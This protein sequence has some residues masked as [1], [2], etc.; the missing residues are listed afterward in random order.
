MKKSLIFIFAICAINVL[1][2][3]PLQNQ[4]HWIQILYSENPN[5]IELKNAY[6]EYFAAHPF[7]KSI[8]TQNYKRWVSQHRSQIGPDGFLK[9]LTAEERE[10]RRDN[11]EQ[12]QS[13]NRGG[14]DIWSYAG[15]EIH[16]V[17]DGT[18][19]EG[20][21]HSN[22][23]C[24]DRSAINAELL[25]CGTES[26]GAYKSV[27]GGMNWSNITASLIIG[28]VESMRI[29]PT[30][31]N[32]VIMS[33]TNDL[34]RTVDGGETWSVIGQP[35]FI[36]QNIR[37]S[38]IVF[39]PENPD[40]IYAATNLGFFR[41][42]D[43]GN[44]WTEVLTGQCRTVAQ[45]PN[46]AAIVYTIQEVDTHT[47]QFF[48]SE[49]YG[50]TWIMYNTGWFDNIG[51]QILPEGGRLAT[52]AAD[53]N[54][55]YAILVGYQE[56]NSTVITNGWI[57]AWVSYDAG[58][59]W[60]FPHGL[61]GSPY[62]L[63][64]HPNLM[65]FQ[66]DDGDYTQIN[67]NTTLIVSQLDPDKVLIGGLNL[68]KSTDAC[69]TYQGV[70]GYI[71]GIDYFHVDQQEYHIYKTSETTEE[72]WFSN[73][74]GIGFSSDFM[75][76]HLNLNRGIQAVNLWGYDQ[77]WNEDMMVGGR[78]HNGNM[79][80]HELYPAKEFLALGGGEAAT[81]YVN[82][83]D[84]NKTYFSDIGGVILPN[85]LDQGPGYFSMSLSPNESYYA[86]SSSR[87]M[88][89]NQYY[90]VA[91]LGKD[92]KL[93][94]STNGG[95][96]FG[97]F[98][99][100][101]TNTAN[102]VLWME[103][104]YA[105]YNIM[106]V[107]QAIGNNSQLWQTT[108]GGLT[109][110]EVNLPY[111]YREMV[112]TLSGTNDDELWI[113]YYYGSNGNK[114]YH[115]TDGGLNWDNITSN[116]FDGE[117]PWAIAHQYGT[118]GGVYLAV[119]NGLVFYKNNSISE[120]IVY[121][122]GLPAS[123]EPLRLVPFYKG[124]K[125]RLATWNLG[126]WE[127][128]FYESSE[129][130]VDFAA[131]LGTYYCPGDEMHFTDHSV[132]GPDATY[133]WSI[134]GATPSTSTEKN[135]TVVYDNSGTYDVTLSVTENGITESVTKT[136]YISSQ[137]SGSFPTAEG[138]ESSSFPEDWK[139]AHSSGGNGFWSMA[140]GIGGYG[141]SNNSM[142]FD[143][144]YY[145]ALG[146]RDEIWLEKIS[147]PNQSD[148]SPELKFDVAYAQYNDDPYTDTLAVLISADC[149]QSWTEIYVKGGEDLSTA[150]DYSTAVFVPG[151]TQWS[152]DMISLDP[153]IGEPEVIVA[154]Q[155]RGH[156]GQAIY[157]DNI[158]LQ[159]ST[160]V[161]DMAE[162][163]AM[164]LNLYP[165]PVSDFLQLSAKNITPS[166]VLVSIFDAS[167]KLVAEEIVKAGGIRLEK[168]MDVSKLTSGIYTL[169]LISGGQRISRVFEVVD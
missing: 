143:N 108:D 9:E 147:F 167:G 101:G 87:I 5:A 70:G 94:R 156:Y 61:I 110:T 161:D 109:F 45:K 166:N 89:D 100:F 85:S 54:R 49:D 57:G 56:N 158:N 160:G 99:A 104:S 114:V 153:F 58:V 112:F 3:S 51:N 11:I 8:H 30:N 62:I 97:E 105:N 71:G 75:T 35:A 2:Q 82:Y 42:I 47:S 120:W 52:T 145:D 78:Y 98:Y 129:L 13:Q 96:S 16:Y 81:G 146:G 1:G 59:T 157:V 107:H 163:N 50:E 103:Q 113:A 73:D 12:L 67:Y 26:G 168:R 18:L 20:F 38:E 60:E 83:S 28:S 64:T 136:A 90:N 24:H 122:S 34:W 48:K 25:Y 40:I 37:A 14:G 169:Q 95:S 84:E 165:N 164:E 32:I 133:S 126:V 121:A 123:T 10:R 36:S 152:T 141:Q 139:P 22:I 140:L 76:T 23:Y 74:G 77:G 142:K 131:M 116:L 33:A 159:I 66:A 144:Y 4:P 27:D 86:N 39:N 134:P 106:Y 150:P 19:N 111:N 17:S 53:P 154:F 155:N 117:E 125:I 127:A 55:I 162:S 7:K 124:G 79:A 130:I 69:A 137:G 88:F 128:T 15:P 65:N 43:G 46:D 6:E 21:R 102:S 119:K 118:D 41:S 44:N 138:F 72:I 151:A 63:E 68:W 92:N 149:G 93:Y 132:A 29:H 31:D 135:P 148:Y 91:W 80:Y 115:T